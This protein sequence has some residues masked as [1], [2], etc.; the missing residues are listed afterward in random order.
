MNSQFRLTAFVVLF[1]SFAVQATNAADFNIVDYGAASAKGA[2]ANRAA[3]QRAVDAAA[4]NGGRVIVPAGEFRTGTI[5]LKSKV[6]LH[7]EKGARLVGSTNRADYNDDDVFPGNPSSVAEEWS[8]A[9]L[10]YAYQAEDVAI[11]GEGTIDGSGSSFFGDCDEDSRFPWYKYGLKLRTLNREWYRPGFMVTFVECRGILLEDVT[12]ANTPCWTC[13]VR[14]SSGFTA[15]RVK[16]DADRALANSDGFSIDCSRD[17]LIE[18]CSVSTGDDAIPIRASCKLHC[19]TN[20]CENIIVRDCDIRSCCM[21]FRLGVGNGTVRNVTIENCR[22]HEAAN[23]IEFSPSFGTERGV[24][25][26]NVTVRGCSFVECD[27]PVTGAGVQNALFENCL[28][29][30]LSPIYVG[31]KVHFRNCEYRRIPALKVR[32]HGMKGIGR[33]R[34][35]QFLVPREGV[36]FENCRPAAKRPGV[37][38]LAFDDR[39]FVAWERAIPLF[40]RYGAHATFFISG[41]IADNGVRRSV[42]RLVEAGHSIGLHGQ[43]HMNVDDA[44]KTIG[45]R[46]HYEKELS[47][48]LRQIWCMQM[49]VGCFAYPNNRRNDETDRYL[50]KRFKRLR[51]GVPGA[52]PYDPKGEKQANRIPLHE[53]DA[54]FFPV[55]ELPKRR[56]ISGAIIGEAYHTRIDE[57]LKCLERAAA[58][59]EVVE[60]T[61]HGISPDAKSI[62]MKTEWLEKIL[63]RAK[64]LGLEVLAFDE[65]D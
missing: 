52:A 21:G 58:R 57:V 14:C 44:L 10:V 20:V 49:P 30:G 39:N 13:H 43:N 23:A 54:L 18:G 46:A 35:R 8:G 55:D 50:L 60:F 31:G 1:V 11:T 56:V 33:Q 12:L 38:V 47:R 27:G 40:R 42:K 25:I 37:L 63:V 41:E 51:A 34:A 36:T 32:H 2:A 17:V 24:A 4:K 61:S 22:V 5:V 16:I 6:E 9:H 15:R 53:N 48:P 19:H 28:F 3:I 7:L 26:S 64:E 45:E 29:E 62:N 65:L 59:R